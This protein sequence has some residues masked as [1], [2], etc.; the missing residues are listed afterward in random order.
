MNTLNLLCLPLILCSPALGDDSQSIP[1]SEL[2]S[3]FKLV[4]KLRQ[5]AHL[6]REPID[7]VNQEQIDLPLTREL[8]RCL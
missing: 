7:A 2:G 5:L 3:K 6:P 4:G 8:E 1:V